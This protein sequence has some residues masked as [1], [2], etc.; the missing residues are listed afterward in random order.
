MNAPARERKKHYRAC[1][2]CEA[3]CGV[4]IETRGTEILSIKG[5]K[6]DPLSRGHLCPKA[7]ALKD[8]H[9]D[10][11]RLRQPLKRV[12]NS[13]GE[14]SWETIS[15]EEALTSAAQG[16][17]DVHERYG[18]HAI[19][20]YMGNPTVHNYGMLTHQ[21]NLFRHFRTN[22]RF[23]ATSVDQLPHH[24]ASLWLFGH[25]SLFPIPDIDHSDYMLMLGANPI[26]SNGSIWT[27]PDVKKRL[28]AVR[29]RGGKIVVLDPRYTETAKVASEHHFIK[30][31]TDALFLLAIL[32]T[33]L[34]LM[35]F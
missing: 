6:D 11:D 13:A 29:A 24:L 17:V 18:V 25:K 22:N 1:H 12:T 28:K 14:N 21:G 32:N 2:L 15:W 19:G 8:L 23:S 26:A 7:I 16:L 30:P 5:D 34:F 33:I 27:V 10:P 20:V 9:E 3:I 31:G 4:V 35:V